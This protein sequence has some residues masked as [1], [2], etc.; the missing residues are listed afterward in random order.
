MPNPKADA[1]T[2]KLALRLLLAYLVASFLATALSVT[3]H[4]PHAHV[5]AGVVLLFFPM[6]PWAMLGN[7][8]SVGFGWAEALS[9]GVFVSVFGGL[10]GRALRRHGGRAG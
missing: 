2:V 3:L 10:A 4:P 9:L 7:L 8:F 6:V 1:G 5:P